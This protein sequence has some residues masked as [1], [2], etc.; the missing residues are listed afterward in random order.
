MPTIYSTGLLA[1]A[2]GTVS[3]LN[4]PIKALVVDNGYTFDKSDEFVSDVTGDE[5]TNDT[6]TGYERKTL[7]AKTV[8]LA[9]DVVTYDADDLIYTAVETNETW[10]ALIVYAEGTSDAN[11]L[12][13]AYLD[14]DDLVTNGSDVTVTITGILGIDNS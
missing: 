11:S 2:N 7:T 4:S 3:W 9:S 10:D 1:L 8:T 6:G 12:L 13:L 5:V 14:I